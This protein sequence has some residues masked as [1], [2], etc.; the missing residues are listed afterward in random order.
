[1]MNDLPL[2]AMRSRA[3]GR[4]RPP[5]GRR[6][7]NPS[8]F[9]PIAYCSTQYKCEGLSHATLLVP[10]EVQRLDVKFGKP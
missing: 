1:M 10:D 5:N 6:T 9:S 7:A 3:N 4:L 2:P 8:H